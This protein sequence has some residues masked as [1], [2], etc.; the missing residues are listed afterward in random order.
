[1]KLKLL[2]IAGEFLE[3]IT[4]ML[5]IGQ[6]VLLLVTVGLLAAIIVPLVI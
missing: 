4:G 3:E 2:K 1:M 5:T 6:W